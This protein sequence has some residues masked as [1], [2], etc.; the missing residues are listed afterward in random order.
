MWSLH[1][2]VSHEPAARAMHTCLECIWSA[3]LGA[4]FDFPKRRLFLSSDKLQGQAEIEIKSAARSIWYS[5]PCQRNGTCSPYHWFI[6]SQ[7]YSFYVL[8]D[9]AQDVLEIC[10]F[11]V[12]MRCL[13]SI[14]ICHDSVN[15]HDKLGQA[16]PYQSRTAP[17]ARRCLT[18]P[19]P[20]LPHY[21]V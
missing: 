10:R 2:A 9:D 12:N 3:G 8:E 5:A 7:A 18:R 13:P 19:Q 15:E 17:P 4:R 20:V 21:D 1:V 14:P 16:V 11:D 6:T